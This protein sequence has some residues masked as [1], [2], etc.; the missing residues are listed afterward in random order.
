MIKDGGADNSKAPPTA[1][2]V[3]LNWIE[4]LKEKLPANSW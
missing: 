4:E 3:S 1:I 2:T